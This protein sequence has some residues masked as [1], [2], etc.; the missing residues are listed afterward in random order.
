MKAP[1]HSQKHYVQTTLST[2]ATVA[3]AFEVLIS[4]VAVSSKDA[5]NEVEEGAIVKAIFIEYWLQSSSNDGSEI[6]AITK[7]NDGQTGPTYTETLA[8]DDYK[9]KKNVLF[10][11]QGLSSND[12]VGNPIPAFR[13]W[14]KIPKGKQR[15]GAGDSLIITFANPSVNTLNYCGFATYKEYL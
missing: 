4:A 10:V 6:I 5:A 9:T 7:T 11:H 2:V 8:L 15:F 1:I 12:G 3:R 14:V 13:G